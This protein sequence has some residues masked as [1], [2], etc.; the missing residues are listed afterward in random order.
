[1]GVRLVGQGSYRS[2]NRG[3]TLDPANTYTTHV[4]LT[5]GNL[6]AIATGG[7]IGLYGTSRSTV[8]HATGRYYCEATAE[9]IGGSLGDA[10]NS[11]GVRN[12]AEDV[13]TFNGGSTNSLG[14]YGDGTVYYGGSI[15]TTIAQF[16]S[17]SSIIGTF[18]DLTAGKIWFYDGTQWNNDILA[19]QNPA[20]NT[21]GIS[22]GAIV[23]NTTVYFTVEVDAFPNPTS[24]WTV[25][26][27][28]TPYVYAAAIPA[29][30]LNW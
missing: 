29:G 30:T 27:G 12:V 18:A 5:N 24:A 11:L 21:G 23:G 26:F 19:N 17:A 3:T 25:N 13:T 15:L 20:T 14:Y 10:A 8:G 2:A 4:A 28:A 16:N 6:R 1:M 22:L 7:T 9:A